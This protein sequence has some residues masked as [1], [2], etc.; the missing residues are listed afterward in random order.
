MDKM[1]TQ[2]KKI[3]KRMNYTVDSEYA[4]KIRAEKRAYYAN[5]KPNT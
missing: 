2:A 5:I 1:K 3:A 4:D